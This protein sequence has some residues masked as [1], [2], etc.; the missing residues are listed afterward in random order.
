MNEPT[1]IAGRYRLERLVGQGGIGQVFYGTDL[2]TD[3]PAAVKALKPH[4]VEQTPV[5]WNAS[6]ARVRPLRN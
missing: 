3:E 1:I 2:Q 4:V 5:C 6:A